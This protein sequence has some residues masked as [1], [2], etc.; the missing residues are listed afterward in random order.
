MRHLGTTCIAFL[1]LLIAT[2]TACLPVKTATIQ[3][4]GKYGE[5]DVSQIEGI[6]ERLGFSR[7]EVESISGGR[8]ARAEHDGEMVSGFETPFGTADAGFGVSILWKMTDG[9]IRVIFAERNTRF[10][11]RGIAL[12]D[13]LVEELR[14]LY[15][16]QVSI[17]L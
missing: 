1:T 12:K 16:N 5:A 9:S 3:F 10:S 13:K 17:Q 14:T 4:S 15:G 11:D 7:I 2:F 6:V 8:R